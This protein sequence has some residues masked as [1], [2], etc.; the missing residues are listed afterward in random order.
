MRHDV[1]L[2]KG[3]PDVVWVAVVDVLMQ[4]YES[5]FPLVHTGAALDFKR[6]GVG[7]GKREVL[8]LGGIIG[9]NFTLG[10]NG[11][12][13]LMFVVHFDGPTVGS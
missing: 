8:A 2:E 10:S 4:G 13:Q 3:G 12:M 11:D 7:A 9:R 6:A 5:D 1:A